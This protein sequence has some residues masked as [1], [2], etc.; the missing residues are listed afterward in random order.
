MIR[1]HEMRKIQ[2]TSYISCILLFL[3]GCSYVNT[4]SLSPQEKAYVSKVSQHS[5]EFTIPDSQV[6]NAWGR[7]QS[8]IGKYS[9]SKI[10]T[11]TD[12]IIQTEEAGQSRPFDYNVTKTIQK[13]SSQITVRCSPETP[14]GEMNAHILAY[15]IE[16]GELPYPRLIAGA[17]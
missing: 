4:L 11:A 9:Y 7:A 6:T 2:N 1:H 17:P 12:Y 5:L 15:Y 14:D 3:F 16:F 13:D 8:F 10:K